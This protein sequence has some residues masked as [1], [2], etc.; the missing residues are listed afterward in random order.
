M[1]GL[2]STS[3]IT[4]LSV[5]MPTGLCSGQPIFAK[6]VTLSPDHNSFTGTFSIGQYDPQGNLLPPGLLYGKVQAKRITVQS[7]VNDVL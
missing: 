2:P 3:S 7:T 6:T 4:S 1:W 5:G